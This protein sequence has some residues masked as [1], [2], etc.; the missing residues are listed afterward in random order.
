[1]V[2]VPVSVVIS[3]KNLMSMMPGIVWRYRREGM[4]AVGFFL[5]FNNPAE[6]RPEKKTRSL[7]GGLSLTNQSG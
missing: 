4:W 7:R 6:D 3:L 1:L 5:I 2:D